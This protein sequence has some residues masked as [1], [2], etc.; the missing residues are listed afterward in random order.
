MG[1][2]HMGHPFTDYDCVDFVT[3]MLVAT[4]LMWWVYMEM[5]LL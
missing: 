5:S 1:G 2:A 3:F 4:G